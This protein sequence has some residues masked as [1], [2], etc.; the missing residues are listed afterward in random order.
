MVTLFPT[1]ILSPALVSKEFVPSK[2][3][4][5]TEPLN[6]ASPVLPLTLNLGVLIV[7]STKL[8]TNSPLSTKLVPSISDAS[9]L[10]LLICP[11]DIYSPC[12]TV[13]PPAF[14]KSVKATTPSNE[15]TSVTLTK[16]RLLPL[17]MFPS[18][19]FSSAEKVQAYHF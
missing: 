4:P 19:S 17:A 13:L 14:S 5:F 9:G 18:D 1:V 2:E 15:C 11:V 7:P 12:I 16:V 3:P 10:P 8:I 6:S